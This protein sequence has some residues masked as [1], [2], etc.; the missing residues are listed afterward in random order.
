MNRN[1]LKMFHY[2][3]ELFNVDV[4]YLDNIEY[5]SIKR[6]TMRARICANINKDDIIS[7]AYINSPKTNKAYNFSCTF[8]KGRNKSWEGQEVEKSLQAS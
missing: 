6:D 2:V 5:R 4:D 1:L 7:Y 3:A 8:K